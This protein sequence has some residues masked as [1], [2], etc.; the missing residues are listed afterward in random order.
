MVISEVEMNP[1]WKEFLSFVHPLFRTF[2]HI[3]YSKPPEAN[4]QLLSGP[5]AAETPALQT[6]IKPRAQQHKLLDQSVPLRTDPLLNKSDLGVVA[7]HSD[8]QP[9]VH[10]CV[11]DVAMVSEA[12]AE[13]PL[14][15]RDV[16]AQCGAKKNNQCQK[17][18]FLSAAA[19]ARKRAKSA[20]TSLTLD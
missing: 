6:C 2:G 20:V 5:W 3:V 10:D 8:A 7:K 15:A 18:V 11:M 19:G 17:N 13:S 12:A 9:S 1:L 16:Q 14:P 4:N